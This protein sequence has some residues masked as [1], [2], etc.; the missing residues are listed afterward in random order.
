MHQK[1]LVYAAQCRVSDWTP[2]NKFGFSRVKS[3]IE[4]TWPCTK[5]CPWQCACGQ[6]FFFFGAEIES[7]LYLSWL[8]N[9]LKIEKSSNF[10]CSTFFQHQKSNNLC[11]KDQKSNY[12]WIMAWYLQLRET[13][14]ILKKKKKKKR[15]RPNGMYMHAKTGFLHSHAVCKKRMFIH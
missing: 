13:K 11:K 10:F 2:Q 3:S 14:G 15:E 7:N 5:N 6:V 8:S 9:E 4:D 12:L 1:P